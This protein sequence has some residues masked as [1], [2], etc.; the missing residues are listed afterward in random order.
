MG[1]PFKLKSKT[2]DG[3]RVHKIYYPPMTPCD[4]L[5]GLP[6]VADETKT[7]LRAQFAVLDPVRLLQEIR[8]AHNTRWPI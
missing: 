1:P 7:R 2:R 4:R 8:A 5:L 3:A 6:T